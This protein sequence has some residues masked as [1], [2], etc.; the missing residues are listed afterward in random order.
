MGQPEQYSADPAGVVGEAHH[1]DQGRQHK[2]AEQEGRRALPHGPQQV[3]DAERHMA[4][5]EMQ[6]EH[7]CQ[8]HLDGAEHRGEREVV[9]RDQPD[10]LAQPSWRPPRTDRCAALRYAVA[11]SG[12]GRWMRSG[13]LW[14]GCRKA[15]PPP[16]STW[17]RGPSSCVVARVVV[18]AALEVQQQLGAAGLDD[19]AL[20][21]L[22][23]A[24]R[25][26]LVLLPAALNLFGHAQDDAVSRLQLIGGDVGE[27]LKLGFVDRSSELDVDAPQP[28]A[29]GELEREVA[30]ALARPP[31]TDPAVATE[32][33]GEVEQPV[34]PVVG[35]R[36]GEQ[37]RTVLVG[38]RKRRP[39]RAEHAVLILSG[40]GHRVHLVASHDEDPAALRRIRLAIAVELELLARQQPGHRV[41]RVPPVAEVGDV[42]DPQ[43]GVRGAIQDLGWLPGLQ[44]PVVGV[45]AEHA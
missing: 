40:L 44:F 33:A 38:A 2:Q 42:V 45:G 13:R 26:D 43:L 28:P 34:V 5:V 4:I 15:P 37:L 23:V 30:A 20:E 22:H 10:P 24:V 7:E 36:N 1:P 3:V 18:L 11:P 6:S 39:V 19:L 27:V 14:V 17:W 9:G 32:D 35:A 21:E 41:G 8:Q 25:M 29:V 16:D 12:P 31:T